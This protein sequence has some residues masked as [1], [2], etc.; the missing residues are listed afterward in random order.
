MRRSEREWRPYT[1]EGDDTYQLDVVV[2]LFAIML[3]ILVALAAASSAADSRV[4]IT[5]RTADSGD[6]RFVPAS[7]QTPY[8]FNE[9]WAADADGLFE[10]DRGAVVSAMRDQAPG[11][12]AGITGEGADA[13]LLTFPDD[14]LG[15]RLRL[16]LHDRPAAGWLRARDIGWDDTAALQE[17][18]AE[19]GGVVVFVWLSGHERLPLLSQLLRTTMRPHRLYPFSDDVATLVIEYNR[20]NF[21]YDKVLR[22]Y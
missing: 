10:I 14:P 7:I 22:A 17:W 5:Y 21:A 19:D 12:P 3:V 9:V 15:W 8:A 2:S 16:N 4:L 13:D 1:G 6:D 11:A 20:A 18:A